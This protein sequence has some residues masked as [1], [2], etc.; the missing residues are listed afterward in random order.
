MSR[1]NRFQPGMLPLFLLFCAVLAAIWLRFHP[2]VPAALQGDDLYYLFDYLN[3]RCATRPSEIFT[4]VCADRFRPLASGF[5]IAEMALFGPNAQSYV[6]INSIILA[7]TALLVFLTS[8]ILSRGAVIVALAV[9]L[10]VI[11]SRFSLFHFSAVL[12]PVES[13]TLLFCVAV[14]YCY[15]RIDHGSSAYRWAILA[16]FA[17]MLATFTHERTLVVAFWLMPAFLLSPRLRNGSRLRL[18]ALLL[19]CIAVPLFYIT[20]KTLVLDTHFLIGTSGTSISFDYARIGEHCRQ[21]V[22]SLFGFNSGPE[23][24]AGGNVTLAWPQAYFFALVFLASWVALLVIGL[25]STL[26]VARGLAGAIEAVRW[27]VVLAGFMVATLAPALLTIRVEHRWLLIPFV[28]VMLIPAWAVGVTSRHRLRL[29][30]ITIAVLG[31]L[32]LIRVDTLVTKRYDEVFFV[33]SM[34]FANAAFDEVEQMSD[35]DGD[36]IAIL[37]TQDVCEWTLGHGLFFELYSDRRLALSCQPSLES[38]IEG[39][40]ADT[41]LYGLDPQGSMVDLS[42]QRDSLRRE[43]ESTRIDFIESFGTGSINDSSPV[44]APTG[45][46]A[47]VMP[48]SAM[49]GTKSTLT[50]VSGFE[51]RFDGIELPEE[52]ELSLTFAMSM[53]YPSPTRARAL[54]NI[55]DENGKAISFERDL[56]AP[57]AGAEALEFTSQVVRLTEFAGRSVSVRFAVQSPYGQPNGHWVAFSSP[58][59]VVANP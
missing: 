16:I 35:D 21:A 7:L 11:L 14:L 41:R 57:A 20:Y 6:W 25:L 23:Y 42:E 19:A 50:V 49:D 43:R 51:Y 37:A 30:A 15:A 5:I 48:W 9:A 29:V 38:E 10:S 24:V 55:V 58:R 56:D 2:W 53:T 32:A 27:P 47:F 34:N 28:A 8:L 45:R 26:R 52:G 59:I 40:S 18:G 39:I 36:N 1:A 44:S 22:M 3:Q 31:L 46:G 17:A 33:S 54:V 13:L 12:G 4:A